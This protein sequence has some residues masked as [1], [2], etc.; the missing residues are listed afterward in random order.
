[1]T[2]GSARAELPSRPVDV[3][4]LISPDCDAM[5]D[6][7]RVLVIDDEP[8]IRWSCAQMLTASGFPV[9]EGERGETAVSVL[10]NPNGGALPPWPRFETSSRAYI[11][12]T[13][14]GPAAR[15]GLRRPYCDLF[16]EN[17]TRLTKTP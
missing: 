17:V 14:A 1:M 10:G 8:L 9:I 13:A 6:E 16:V 3:G 15:E 11:Q 2:A 5:R 7:V 12:F 4:P